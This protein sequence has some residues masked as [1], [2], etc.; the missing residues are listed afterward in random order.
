MVVLEALTRLVPGVLGNP[1]STE[2]ESFEGGLL[3]G[4][5]YTRPATY[6]GLSVPDVL[7]SGDH[8]AIDQWRAERARERT[9]KRRPDLL[10][11]ARG[12]EER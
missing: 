5:Q 9:Q 7:R 10:S 8:A 3:E 12:D 1:E 4:P 6:R 11:E 2:T